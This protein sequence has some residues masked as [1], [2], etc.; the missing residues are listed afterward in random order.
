VIMS[1]IP[2]D[3]VKQVVDSVLDLPAHARTAFLNQACPE[4]SVRRY[5]ESLVLSF[6]QASQ[7][8]DEPAAVHYAQAAEVSGDDSW[9]GRRVGPYQI[10]NEIGRGGMGAVYLAIRADDQYRKEVAIKVVRR[11]F[12]NAI[13]LTRFKA[14]RQIL[15]DLEH[16][17][18]A[19]LLEGGSTEEGHP[20]FVMEYIQG[21]P[22]DRYCD[23]NRL[24][25]SE[26]LKLF[27]NVCSAVQYAHQK[28]VVHRDLK[29]GNILVTRQ[30]VPKLLD[31][32]IAKI[33]GPDSGNPAADRTATMVRALTPE[34]ASP[35]QWRGEA[36]TTSSDVYSLGVVLYE[37]LTG[38]RPY[39]F[40]DQRPEEM[41][42][43]VAERE[44]E[45]PSSAVLLVEA[46]VQSGGQPG[47]RTP[48][49]VSTTREGTPDKLRRRLCGDLDNIILMALRKEPERRYATVDQLAEDLRRHLEGL[50]VLA[51]RDTFAYRSG[52]F[53]RRNAAMVTAALLVV[54]SLS[55]GLVIA[56][57]QAHIARVE[58][59]RAERRFNDVRALA[60]SLMFEIHDAIQDLPGSTSARKLLVDRAVQYLDSLAKESGN[61]PSLQR[62]L[63]VAYEKIGRVQ[64]NT[65]HGS[66][67]DS[68]RALVSYNK[69][70]AI[71]R[72]LAASSSATEADRLS[73]A[74]SFSM[75]GR[76][77]LAQGKPQEALALTRQSVEISEAEA[78]AQSASQKNKALAQLQDAYDALG[79]VLSSNG[80]SGSLGLLAE[81]GQV[82]RKAV[83]LGEER[84]RLYPENHEYQ[85]GLAVALVKVGN[86]QQKMGKPKEALDTYYRARDIIEKLAAAAP[87]NAMFRRYLAGSYS[88]IGDAQGQSGNF[89]GMLEA[90]QKV[91]H[92]TQEAAAADPKNEQA[93]DDLA[94]AYDGVGYA[95]Y[96]LGQSN[97]AKRNLTAASE[98]AAKLA[99]SDSTNTDMKHLWAF[100]EVY[101]GYWEERFGATTTALQRYRLALSIWE[102]VASAAPSDMDTSVRVASIE[103]RIGRVLGKMGHLEEAIGHEQKALAQAKTIAAEHPGDEGPLYVVADSF[104]ALGDAL[105]REAEQGKDNRRIEL[106]REAQSDYSQGEQTWRGVP[107][108]SRLSPAGF[109]TIGPDGAASGLGRCDAALNRIV[110][111]RDRTDH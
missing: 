48:Q 71:R 54:I 70:M 86:D 101:L 22:L 93:Q 87:G 102:S 88:A 73:L 30:G 6:E 3:R 8:L 20:Y 18:I 58:R 38:H 26:R 108:P 110:P 16:P 46:R 19:R 57:R 11:G 107:N 59:V 64:G 74:R 109:E 9:S 5:V 82:H 72:E 66:L 42:R 78:Q 76:F 53:V 106:W 21:L 79:D 97:E 52:K 80:D 90:Y 27:R 85:L 15:A 104:V 100:S 65:A 92:T 2:W 67:G 99:A 83:A 7:F 103:S 75:V 45:R 31:F 35:E 43:V 77:Y 34:Y 1:T 28:L 55:I 61:D 105:A 96:A 40:V 33:L 62:E 56:L 84:T 36:I 23:E 63:A 89:K 91:L 13:A 44:P 69:A 4:T 68:T 24:N 17:N 39:R 50:P 14:E 51:R 94:T 25:V 47:D 60:N 81:A 95:Q 10:V 49:S 12:D 111:Q 29:P 32:G 41:D 98:I 37:L